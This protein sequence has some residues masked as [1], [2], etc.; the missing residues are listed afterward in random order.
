MSDPA[1]LQAP[2]I[3]LMGGPGSG[4][5]TSLVTAA[6]A[7][8]EVFVVI[9]EPT[10][11]ESLLDA[12][13]T[14]K[15]PIE[16]LHYKQIAPSRVGMGGL[17]EASKKVAYSDFEALAKQKPSGDR[18]KAQW[19]KLLTQFCDFEDER[20]GAKY[21]PVELFDSSRFLAVDSLSGINLMAMDMVVGD[22]LSAH[23]GEWGVAMGLI[24]KLILQLT[25]DLKCTFCL[26]A[27]LEREIDEITGGTRIMASA[28]GRKLAPRLPRFFSEVVMAYREN[29]SFYW[30][31][32]ANTVDLK[33]R[34]LPL[35][36][37]LEPNFKPIVDAFNRRIAFAHIAGKAA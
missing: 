30:S 22:K 37:K 36:S 11:V 21:G 7:G 3:L 9:T 27:H 5:T 1:P 6:Q 29:E 4:K 32:T 28:L 35:S 12:F 14:R 17:L 23:Q 2:S 26:T 33:K 34:A 16:R 24:E 25:S 31:T 20:T 8:L 15:V 13:E 19:L 18:S 10:G